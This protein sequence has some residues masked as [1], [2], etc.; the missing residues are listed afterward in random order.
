VALNPGQKPFLRSV[1]A[2][3]DHGLSPDEND[4]EALENDP[5]FQRLVA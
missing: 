5:E 2:P 4:L 3:V 1:A